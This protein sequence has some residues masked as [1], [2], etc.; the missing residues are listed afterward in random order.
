MSVRISQSLFLD[1][2]HWA[3]K[4]PWSGLSLYM[5]YCN[6]WWKIHL[7]KSVKLITFWNNL[8]KE[9]ASLFWFCVIYTRC[10]TSS[11][12]NNQI[13]NCVSFN[14]HMPHFLWL[15]WH[16]FL[17]SIPTFWSVYSYSSLVHFSSATAQPIL[18]FQIL[19]G[20]QIVNLSNITKL[21]YYAQTITSVSFHQ[22]HCYIGQILLILDNQ[23]VH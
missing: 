4:R 15:Y 18:Q 7:N 14:E 8:V 23:D 10:C 21:F 17:S 6:Q 13:H 5:I 1:S 22:T 20:H 12:Q 9:S 3:Y 19:S 11:D 16:L 2:N